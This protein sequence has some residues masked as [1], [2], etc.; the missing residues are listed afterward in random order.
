MFF[1]VSFIVLY[2]LVRS[3]SFFFFAYF[4]IFANTYISSEEIG[5]LIFRFSNP[6]YFFA[7]FSFLMNSMSSVFTCTF[8]VSSL[9]FVLTAFLIYNIA[10]YIFFSGHFGLFTYI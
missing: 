2:F 7:M 10:T 1:F 8:L 5:C 9:Y 3:Y 4:G 6:P